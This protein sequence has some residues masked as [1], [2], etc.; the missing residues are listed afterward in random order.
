MNKI[1]IRK[2]IQL[3]KIGN[4]YMI[5]DACAGNVNMSKVYSLNQ[6]AAWIWQCVADGC[7]TLDELTE[8]L[9]QEYKVDAED[10]R[11]VLFSNVCR[12]VEELVPF[13]KAA[14]CYRNCFSGNTA[15]A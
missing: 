3:R 7:T 8:R 1:E 11:F 13:V 12:G 2:G 15:F 10:R 6:T 4:R 14:D 5:V 9:C